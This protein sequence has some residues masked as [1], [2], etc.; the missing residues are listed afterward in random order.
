MTIDFG[1]EGSEEIFRINEV[2]GY[3]CY[4][5]KR[6]S[7]G[8][9]GKQT[10][11]SSSSVR[12]NDVAEYINDLSEFVDTFGYSEQL[13]DTTFIVHGG[14]IQIGNEVVELEDKVF[15]LGSEGFL[16]NQTHKL[17]VNQITKQFEVNVV[18][19]DTGIILS[20][21]ITDND[22]IITLTRKMPAYVSMYGYSV[23]DVNGKT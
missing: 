9:N 1:I 16:I 6:I 14:R 19:P 3:R 21:I 22:K 20:E 12:I 5:D 2:D 18:V 23:L 17:F 13:T 10:H 7:V 4:F 15:T 8:G 11:I